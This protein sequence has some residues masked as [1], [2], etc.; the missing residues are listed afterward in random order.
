MSQTQAQPVTDQFLATQG[1]VVPGGN[2]L[3][4]DPQYGNIR[5][6]TPVARFSYVTLDNPREIPG[7][8]DK[9]PRYSVTLLL[10]PAACGDIF[11]AICAVA[12]H[13]W[14]AAQRPNPNNPQEMIMVSGRQ[15]LFWDKKF[16]G[17]HYPLRDGNDQ[18]IRD[19]AKYGAFRGL[20]TLNPSLSSKTAKGDAQKPV[21]VDE[22]GQSAD[23]KM[24]YSGC[25]GRA[26]ITIGAFP[27]PGQQIPNS[28]IS[29]TLNSVQFIAHGEKLS[30][31]DGLSAA[32][33]AFAAA[34]AVSG[35]SGYSPPVG[36]GPNTAG[37]GNVP[38]G[39]PGAP[40]GFAAPPV[41]GAQPGVAVGQPA[42]VGFT[43]LQQAAAPQTGGARPPGM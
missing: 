23:P 36:F 18:Y 7:S 25:Y 43:Q 21:L 6:I 12:D 39:V 28:G 26:Q 30:G 16:G 1:A 24:F 9:T 38:P 34:G 3:T 33:N 41:A 37:A 4:I 10:N 31:F 42:P 15:L 29:L 17:L 13:R 5:M 11:N 8:N 40:A 20:F 32:T 22:K 19:P 14:P 35:N 27:K 2:N